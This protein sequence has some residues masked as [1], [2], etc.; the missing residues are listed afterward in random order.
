MKTKVILLS[1][2]LGMSAVV[3]AQKKANYLI[4]TESVKF[5][6]NTPVVAKTAESKP[7]SQPEKAAV[8]KQ[9]QPA[10][11]QPKAPEKPRELDAEMLQI[12]FNQADVNKN[13][14][15]EESEQLVYDK[16]LERARR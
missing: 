10:P 7:A 9:E 5:V 16:M 3:L 15:L 1:L 6:T 2:L 8:S 13:G 14:V 4:T 11:Q 12:L